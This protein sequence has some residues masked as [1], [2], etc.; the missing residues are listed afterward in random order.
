M[1]KWSYISKWI[2]WLTRRTT[3]SVLR[4]E[5]RSNCC[6]V[7][8]GK[9][10]LLGLFIWP[11]PGIWGWDTKEFVIDA[12]LCNGDNEPTKSTSPGGNNPEPGPLPKKYGSGWKKVFVLSENSDHFLSFD[13]SSKNRDYCVS[14]TQDSNLSHS[15]LWK[16]WPSA[17]PN[18][19]LFPKWQFLATADYT[20]RTYLNSNY[21]N[22]VPPMFTS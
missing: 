5:N 22:G 20:P 21:G 4:W 14:L 16:N 10:A 7:I 18:I 11:W 12:I 9:A 19:F 17:H 8:G 2:Q 13:K 1:I 6:W 15:M 3:S